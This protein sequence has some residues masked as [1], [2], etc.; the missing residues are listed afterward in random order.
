M[1]GLGLY[2]GGHH[3]RG[4]LHGDSDYRPRGASTGL[5]GRGLRI[6]KEKIM[7]ELFIGIR[8]KTRWRGIR[9]QRSSGGCE[10]LWAAD[11]VGWQRT[12]RGQAEESCGKRWGQGGGSTGDE[13]IIQE[14]RCAGAKEGWWS[15]KEFWVWRR[16]SAHL[17]RHLHK[18]Q[19]QWPRMTD[20]LPQHKLLYVIISLYIR[21]KVQ[22]HQQNQSKAW[23]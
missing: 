1:R 20:L 11:E 5:W 4:S 8:S 12:D 18:T 23:C 9:G 22:K 6:Q 15:S 3:R 16:S 2:S 7:A 19:R 10:M 21:M 13:W 17:K 14:E